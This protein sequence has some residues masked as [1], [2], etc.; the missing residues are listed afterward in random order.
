MPNQPI[1]YSLQNEPSKKKESAPLAA[2]YA[3][4]I[5]PLATPHIFTY[6]VPQHIQGLLQPG[7]RVLVSL[8]TKKVWTGIIETI[9]QEQPTFKTK[10]ILVMLDDQPI[11]TQQQLTLFAWMAN[12]YMCTLGEVLKIAL[13]PSLRLSSESTFIINPSFD[14]NSVPLS[15][16]EKQLY[17]V[18][19][20]LGKIPYQK[21]IQFVPK[22]MPHTAINKLL[23]MGMLML[24]EEAKGQYTPKLTTQISLH[25]QYIADETAFKNLFHTLDKHQK[26]LDVLLQYMQYISA[27][28]THDSQE[29]TCYWIDKQQM[30]QGNISR[31]ALENLI[32]KNIFV[33]QKIAI[34]RPS[35]TTFTSLEDQHAQPLLSRNQQKALAEIYKNFEH[36][37]TVLLHGV[38]GSGK[39]ALYAHLIR[40]A[41]ERGEQVLYLLPEIGITT[42]IVRRLHQTFG[43][44]LHLYHSKLTNNQKIAIWHD[45]LKKRVN[46]IIGVRS[47]LLL[48]FSHLKCIIIDEEHD[49]AYK[50]S[51]MPPRYHARDTALV[52]ARQHS[53]KVLLGAATPSLETYYH[54]TTGKYGLVTLKERFGQTPLPVIH[55]VNQRIEKER[56]RMHGE[57]STTLLTVIEEVL[58]KK[59]QTIIFQNRRGYAAY[60]TCQACAWVPTC[61]QCSVS[62]TYHQL[63]DQLIC[64]YCGYQQKV[65]PLC[66]V[67]HTPTLKHIGFGTEKL[68]EVLQAFFPNSNIQR[69]DTDTTRRMRSYEKIIL[70]LE[71]GETDILVGTQM[72]T[73]GLDFDKVAL[74]GVL[75]IDRLLHFPDFR[76]HERCFQI[77]TQVSGR[78]GRR[79]LQGQVLIQ[80]ENPNNPVLTD[81][82]AHDYA[83]MFR[84]ELAERKKFGYPPYVRLLK[85]NCQHTQEWVA[86]Q[87]AEKLVEQLQQRFSLQQILGPQVALVAKV[88]NQYRFHVW[89]KLP[90]IGNRALM[91]QK[92]WMRS[93]SN[94][95]LEQ[96][97]YRQAHIIFDVD[98]I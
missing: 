46:L 93:I 37:E 47:A 35:Y 38:T 75:D 40:D 49:P 72:V 69:M 13:P 55:L 51:G 8:G 18:C 87:L 54:A 97:V 52:L 7:H 98:P 84:C 79:E 21:L 22:P 48:P 88:K 30:Q 45:V 17:Q 91:V 66:L 82:V 14:V 10:P 57:F 89:I 29:N 81:I 86:Q 92:Q 6:R 39:T 53:A 2:L 60:L 36:Y 32:K 43:H 16:L 28:K 19:E 44:Q 68:E 15:S 58:K 95:L 1:I 73:K 27:L 11:V 33:V 3:R 74:V 85:I 25:P 42:Q 41:L 96:K 94:A 23:L 31:T 78:S 12:Y 9:H 5:L 20:E 65:P 24:S 77:L 26:Q 80:T 70:S 83:N 67:C 90:K 59:Q 34:N 62:L 61:Q 64:H 71:K 63:S 50:Q 56:K 76:A 4:V